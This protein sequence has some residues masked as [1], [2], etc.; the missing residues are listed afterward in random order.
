[1]TAQQD[2]GGAAAA[3]LEPQPGSLLARELLPSL[4]RTEMRS[5]CADC[6]EP[7]SDELHADSLAGAGNCAACHT[8]AAWTPASFAHDEFFRFDR[9]H[10]A[11]CVSCHEGPGFTSYTCY[12]C[13]EHT[14]ANIRGEHIEEGIRDFEDCASCHRSGDEHDIRGAFGRARHGG[15]EH[16]DDD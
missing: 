15:D 11:S 1:M 10:P 7:P 3:E 4:L 5:A 12:G 16:D 14:P 2:V 9:D 6:H 8:D 13:H